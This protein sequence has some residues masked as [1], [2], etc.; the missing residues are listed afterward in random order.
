MKKNVKA[1]AFENFKQT[2]S[3]H[4]K[5]N[6]IRYDK[7]QLQPYLDSNTLNVE[8]R[9]LVFNIRA[10]TVNGFKM[11][12]TSMY[13]N[14]LNCKLGCNT[15]DTI[16]HCM[17]CEELNVHIGKTLLKIDDI[18]SDSADV[19]KEAVQVFMPRRN[20]REVITDGTRAYQG[21]TVVDTSTS[22]A[23]GGAGAGRGISPL[24]LL[25]PM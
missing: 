7:L 6:T 14:N 12:F 5:V 20:T 2:Q 9:S 4:T 23:A 1:A 13:R 3:T 8:Q 10:N 11:C 16:D 25:Y 18:Y 17:T 24:Y 19:Q 15:P 22:A 21:H